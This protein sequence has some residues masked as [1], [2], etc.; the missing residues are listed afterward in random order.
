MHSQSALCIRFSTTL[1]C[2]VYFHVQSTKCVCSHRRLHFL[3]SIY[4]LIVFSPSL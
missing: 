3:Y 4:S 2:D 1:Y